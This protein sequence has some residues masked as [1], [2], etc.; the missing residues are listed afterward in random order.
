LGGPDTFVILFL[1]H[2]GAGSCPRDG[3]GVAVANDRARLRKP[4]GFGSLVRSL[5]DPKRLS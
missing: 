4:V 3:I 2:P 5:F 1:I